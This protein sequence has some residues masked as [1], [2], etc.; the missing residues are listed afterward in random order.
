MS[1]FK[2]LSNVARGKMKEIGRN[3]TDDPPGPADPDDLPERDPRRDAPPPPVRRRTMED[4]ATDDAGQ[5]AGNAGGAG[6]P[7][8]PEAKREM[9]A[10]LR[11][12]GLLT[13][14][15]YA[16][17]LASL[18]APPAPPRARKRRL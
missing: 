10:R 1:V 11:E 13:E 4:R 9:L 15:E 5:A 18:D 16:D 3:L 2:R 17:K 14:E 8:T 6:G 7:D 12:E